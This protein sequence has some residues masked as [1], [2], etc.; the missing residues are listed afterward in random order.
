M[1]TR[2]GIALAGFVFTS[3]FFINFCNFIFECGCLSLWSGADAHCNIH[4][5]ADRPHCPVCSHGAAGYAITFAAIAGPQLALA[6]IIKR[7]SSITRLAL[8]LLSFPAFG[9]PVMTLAGWWDSYPVN[10][11]VIWMRM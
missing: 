9:A 6:W 10:R 8:V 2:A 3:L 5:A 11:L 4:Q 7:G 1:R